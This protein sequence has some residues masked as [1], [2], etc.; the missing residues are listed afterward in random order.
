MAPE[1]WLVS[2]HLTEKAGLWDEHLARDQDGEYFCRLLTHASRV[3]FVPNAHVFKRIRIAGSISSAANISDEK[4]DSSFLTVNTYVETLL[5]AEN[6]ARTRGACLKALARW[7]I[8]FYPE[9]PDLFRQLQDLAKEL[10]GS[11]SS[12]E[13]EGK[14]FAIQ[15][16]FGLKTAKRAKVLLPLFRDAVVFLLEFLLCKIRRLITGSSTILAPKARQPH[17]WSV[18]TPREN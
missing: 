15:R 16:G 9:R 11:L 13:L 4:R 6:S 8:Y 10:G 18:D 3:R 14:Y 5:A 12:P 1:T 17:Q 7:S 2:R